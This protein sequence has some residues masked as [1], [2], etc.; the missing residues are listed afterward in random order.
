MA[1]IGRPFA[2]T[3]VHGFSIQG[4]CALRM[5]QQIDITGIGVTIYPEIVPKKEDVLI[6]HQLSCSVV[7]VRHC[8]KN[9][10]VT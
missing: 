9:H 6:D 10:H 2:F 5:T 7:F 8:L 4:F 3:V 1:W